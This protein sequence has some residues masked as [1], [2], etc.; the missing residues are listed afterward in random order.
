MLEIKIEQSKNQHYRSGSS[1]C[2]GA[3][4]TCPDREMH[5]KLKACKMHTKRKNAGRP[6]REARNLF[7]YLTYIEDKS[8]YHKEY[9]NKKNMDNT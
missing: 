5:T 6:V 8:T 4:D 9:Q 1:A 2:D 3:Q 7:Y